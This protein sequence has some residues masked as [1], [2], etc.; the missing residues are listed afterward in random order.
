MAASK[1]L[2]YLP[3]V[4]SKTWL[5]MT[6]VEQGTCLRDYSTSPPTPNRTYSL[7]DLEA[8]LA[9]DVSYSERLPA[10]SRI[11]YSDEP[12]WREQIAF[13][14]AESGLSST[15]D[16]RR[17]QERFK[18]ECNNAL[19][20]QSDAALR[21]VFERWIERFQCVKKKKQFNH[22]DNDLAEAKFS[23]KTGIGWTSQLLEA[24]RSNGVVQFIPTGCDLTEFSLV[25][26]ELGF[27][28]SSKDN[29]FRKGYTDFIKPDGL[30]LRRNGYFTIVEVKGPQDESSLAGPLLQATCAALALVAKKQ[31]LHQ[32]AMQ[33]GQRRPAF[34]RAEIPMQRRSLGIHV[35]SQA[36]NN[37]GPRE[38]WTSEVQSICAAVI[39]AFSQLEYIAYS[40]VTAA[41]AKD[42]RRLRTDYL[43]TAEGVKKL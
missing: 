41:E 37:G 25:A 10:F 29:R 22:W 34:H 6:N 2:V 12:F 18:E 15:V 27:G 28:I 7:D 19:A 31:M 11:R 40:F 9:Q 30:A 17:L 8:L 35:L 1:R 33:R 3:A 38:R 24:S 16:E 36:A 39:R 21:A 4:N 20:K 5:L 13:R 14:N 42:L 32:I 23:A 26:M 43:I